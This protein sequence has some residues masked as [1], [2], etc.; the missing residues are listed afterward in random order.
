MPGGVGPVS[1]TTVLACTRQDRAIPSVQNANE[2]FYHL[3]SRRVLFDRGN[4]FLYFVNSSD[5]LIAGMIRAAL[6]GMQCTFEI[7]QMH[8]DRH[9]FFTGA[10]RIRL[11]AHQADTVLV[12]L[13]VAGVRTAIY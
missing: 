4:G 11:T 7:E 3:D 1:Q 2:I 5:G 12:A 8:L 6:T 9:R 10:R 13:R